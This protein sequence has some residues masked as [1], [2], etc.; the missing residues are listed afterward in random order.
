MVAVVDEHTHRPAAPAAEG[1]GD[2][3]ESGG[4]WMR[5]RVGHTTADLPTH[6]GP[7]AHGRE[8]RVD[9]AADPPGV[10]LAAAHVDEDDE[11]VLGVGPE[12]A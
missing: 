10:E 4:W 11:A 5:S 6:R 2:V 8:H 7:R 3:G 1:D 9:G 12:R